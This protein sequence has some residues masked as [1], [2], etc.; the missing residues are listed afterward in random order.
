MTT[1]DYYRF[2]RFD[3]TAEDA[4]RTAQFVTRDELESILSQRLSAALS[5]RKEPEHEPTV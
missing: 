2:E 5:Q 1:T 3:P 4:A